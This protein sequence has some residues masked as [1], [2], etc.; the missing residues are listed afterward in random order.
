[1][2]SLSRSPH[3]RDLLPR[4]PTSYQDGTIE[5]TLQVQKGP[6]KLFF[7]KMS[8]QTDGHFG[9]RERVISPL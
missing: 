6:E 8:S 2:S 5:T 7:L 4:Q 1:M 3:L 9:T